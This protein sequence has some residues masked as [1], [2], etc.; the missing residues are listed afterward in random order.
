MTGWIWW[1]IIGV[2]LLIGG[3]VALLNPFAATITAQQLTAWI[4]LFGGIAQLVAV[5]HV[6][7]WGARIWTFLLAAA[8]VWLGISLLNHPLAGIV[9]LT[10]VAA[11]MF[12]V[13]G[14]AKVIFAFSCRGTG[15]FWPVLLSGLVSVA[16]AVL[17]FLNFPQ[18][19][20]VLLGVLLAVELISS[21]VTLISFALFA[22]GIREPAAQGNAG[23]LEAEAEA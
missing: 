21:G 13:T 12:L 8:F 4:F 1:L 16:L 19:A 3:I 23:D 11:I 9:A 22:R 6:T 14:L 18:S 2:V 17:V 20:A 5:F 7:G 10:I 15:Y